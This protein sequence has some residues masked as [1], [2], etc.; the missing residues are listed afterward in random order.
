MISSAATAPRSHAFDDLSQIKVAYK[1]RN[2]AVSFILHRPAAR[3]VEVVVREGMQ[4]VRIEVLGYQ[5]TEFT[6]RSAAAIMWRLEVD[7]P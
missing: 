1:A 4:T 5:E 2:G 6:Q 3:V 7:Y